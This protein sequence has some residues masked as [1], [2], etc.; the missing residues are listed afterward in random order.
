MP[1]KP[2]QFNSRST[3]T[4]KCNQAFP[5][6]HGNGF[7]LGDFPLYLHLGIVLRQLIEWVKAGTIDIAVGEKVQQVL[8][9]AQTQFLSKQ[10]SPVGAYAF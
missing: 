8:V 2:N 9:G 4:K 3:I 5:A 1:P 6:F 10:C 7:D